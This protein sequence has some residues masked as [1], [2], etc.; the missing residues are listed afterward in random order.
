MA[1]SYIRRRFTDSF[2]DS[3]PSA[4]ANSFSFLELEMEARVGIEPTHKAFAEPCLT[5]WLPRRQM[6][7]E[8]K[9]VSVGR[10][11]LVGTQEFPKSWNAFFGFLPFQLMPTAPEVAGFEDSGGGDDAGDEVGRGDVEAGIQGGA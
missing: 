2:T 1:R 5:T 11:S 8:A 4:F 6:L 7:C 9:S 3:G 10:K